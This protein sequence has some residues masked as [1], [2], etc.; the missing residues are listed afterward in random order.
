LSNP[1]AQLQK[2]PARTQELLGL[3][4]QEWQQLTQKAIAEYEKQQDSL[5]KSKVRINA[6]GAGRKPILSPEAEI[7][8]CLFYL[9]QMPTFRLL[10]IQFAVSKAQANN[11]VH[12]W[13][14]ILRKINYQ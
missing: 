11:T 9:R 2:Y 6:P 4:Y 7:C 12:K 13:L 1:F 5:N 3:T 14:P 10:G 8:L